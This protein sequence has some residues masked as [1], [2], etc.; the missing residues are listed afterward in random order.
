METLSR[1]NLDLLAA[2]IERVEDIESEI[3]QSKEKLKAA[4]ST[5]A[6][7]GFDVKATKQL[8]KERKADSEKTTKKRRIVELYRRSLGGLAGTPLG[9]WARGWMAEDA[10]ATAADKV[11]ED[12]ALT[13]FMA[14]RK[15]GKP[16]KDGGAKDQPSA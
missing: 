3:G 6:G 12:P 9:D 13:A 2:T 11:E 16:G 1:K 7:D 4:Y 14:K 8:V 15:G 10:R 5:A